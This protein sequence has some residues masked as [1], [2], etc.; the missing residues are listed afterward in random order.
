MRRSKKG[1]SNKKKRVFHSMMEFKKEYS[2]KSFEKE[3]AEKPADAHARGISLAK[4]S[5]DK[6][7]RELTD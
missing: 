6:I 5:L 4:E 7:R 2:P 3:I 1:R